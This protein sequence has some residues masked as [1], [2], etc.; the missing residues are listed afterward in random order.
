MLILTI[1]NIFQTFK[2]NFQRLTWPMEKEK[3]GV[4]NGF[5]SGT[6]DLWGHGHWIPSR[7]G[8]PGLCL[9]GLVQGCDGRD[10]QEPDLCGDLL[11]VLMRTTPL[12]SWSSK[13]SQTSS[14]KGRA[15]WGSAWQSSQLTWQSWKK[16]CT[17]PEK[18]SSNLRKWAQNCDEVFVKLRLKTT[19]CRNS[20]NWQSRSCSRPCG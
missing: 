13:K 5:F 1:N 18:T 14:Q 15:R 10:L 3:T 4:W 8:M 9:E 19:S 6:V 17:L 2:I 7:V 20:W 12:Y 16:I 11:M